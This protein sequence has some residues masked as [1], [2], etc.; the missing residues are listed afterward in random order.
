MKHTANACPR[1]GH[2]LARAKGFTLIEL[3]I[4]VAIIGILAAI[5]YPNYVDYIR[6]ARRADAKSLILRAA[7]QEE[8]IYTQTNA[9]TSGMDRL[10]LPSQTDN[11]AYAVAA[12]ASGSNDQTFR[13]TATAIGD[14]VND[15]CRVFSIDQTGAKTAW[16]GT[17][18][19]QGDDVSDE[20]W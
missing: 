7:N 18:T 3:M 9:Y 13:I 17:Q 14:Q 2:S 1:P 5:A 8:K 6:S 10:G 11:Q 19:G 16:S 20:C 15:E 4:V 12:Q